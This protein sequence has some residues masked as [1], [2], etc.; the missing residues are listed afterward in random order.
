MGQVLAELSSESRWL[1]ISEMAKLDLW[2]VR[3]AQGWV[4]LPHQKLDQEIAIS[5]LH[6]PTLAGGSRGPARA[7]PPLEKS[8]QDGACLAKA[9]LAKPP[10]GPG[11]AT[12]QVPYQPAGTLPRWQVCV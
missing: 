5:E 6:S 9:S 3:G 4:G 12:C 8:S 2:H 1:P 10:Q 11:P 7:A